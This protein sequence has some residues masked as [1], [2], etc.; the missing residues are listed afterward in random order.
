MRWTPLIFF[1]ILFSAC[2][3]P[4]NQQLPSVTILKQENIVDSPPFA[5]CHA[6]TIVDIP[7]NRLLAAW[8]AGPHESHKEVLIYTAI[9]ENGTWSQSQAVADGII[10]DTLRYPTWNP[11][12]FR[13]Q[14]GK[15]A[16]FY[17]VGP[18]PREWW[19]EYKIS[20]DEGKTWSAAVKL[21]EGILGPIKNKPIQLKDGSILHPSSTES[22]DEK[23][24]HIHLEKS[25]NN[26]QNWS[27]I[28]INNDS[29]GVIQP[30]ILTYPN[31][32]LQLLSRSRQNYIIQT[33]SK[34]NGATWGPLSK[35]SL[36][37]PNAGS[38]AVTLHNGW[39][40]LV[41]N[42][43]PAGKDWW[44]GRNRLNVAVSKDGNGWQDI[45]KLE[46]HPEGEYSYPAVI[47][48]RDN[49]VHITYTLD[50]KNIRYVSL[51]VQ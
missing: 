5:S 20:N 27:R 30:S 11:V 6:S 41:Y 24:W 29:F 48:D 21:P 34:D 42:P 15:L 32:D 51:Q 12:L 45:L 38:D 14:S 50:R 22:L 37:N 18:N 3:N 25:D 13:T 35:T 47:Q 40:L 26:F 31:G 43:L 23:I 39:Q 46:N 16:L 33:W 8:F 4:V 2:T 9:H 7:G 36:P 28:N 44:N 19:G 49:I 1:A 17:K 10:N